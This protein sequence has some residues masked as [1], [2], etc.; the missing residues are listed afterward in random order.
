MDVTNKP[1]SDSV[2][3]V[4]LCADCA[5]IPWNDDS[6]PWCACYPLI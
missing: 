3:S 6:G 4:F 5:D 1:D 2:T